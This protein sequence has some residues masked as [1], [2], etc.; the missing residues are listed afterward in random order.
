MAK[1]NNKRNRGQS[2]SVNP[3]GLASDHGRSKSEK[4][5]RIPRKN[6]KYEIKNKRTV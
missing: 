3:Q 2:N 6:K 5:I 1:G 4:Q